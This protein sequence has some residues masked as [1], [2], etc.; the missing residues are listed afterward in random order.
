M[1]NASFWAG[2]R[3]LVTGH[4][5]FKGSWLTLWLQEM[6]AEVFG[7]ALAP[8]T[9]PSLYRLVNGTRSP[10][11]EGIADIRDRVAV[12]ARVMVTRPEIVFHLAAQPLVRAGYRD[13]LMTYE[14]N[15]QGTA[16]L[17]DALRIALDV[18]VVVVVTTDKVYENPETG[19]AF[20][21]TDPLGGHDPYSASKAA[22]EI[23]AASYRQ[24]YF[25]ARKV[26]LATARAGNVIGGGDWA[27]DRLVPDAMRAWNAGSPLEV[28]RPE[29]VR[30]WQH[31]LEPLNG[32]LA[33]AEALWQEPE[34]AHAVN[35]GPDHTA[36]ATV[37][38]LLSIARDAYGEGE[39]R[40]ATTEEG[41]H[42]AG[43]L[44][45]DSSLAAERLG[46]RPAWNLEETVTRTMDWY[47]RLKRGMSARS[48]CLND[49]D[50]FEERLQA[51]AQPERR[52]ATR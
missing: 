42:E 31:V 50:A 28:R 18:R 10:A 47:R 24:S 19:I 9:E 15:V 37:R 17:L 23:V 20:R 38:T 32:Y 7:L 4:T 43:Y 35:F 49:I 30:P 8:P 16:N 6:G 21:E 1:A 44:M 25:A 14:T 22:A 27:E 29:A 33:L 46:Y 40:F 36:A 2:K 41:P 12:A 51:L 39:T 48:L 52:A 5:G 3:V 34:L 13:P 26:A 11:S 45:L